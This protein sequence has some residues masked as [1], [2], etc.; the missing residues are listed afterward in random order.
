MDEKSNRCDD[1]IMET[2][3][4]K[5]TIGHI[6][7]FVLNQFSFTLCLFDELVEY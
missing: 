7:I 4:D 1:H 6:D 3:Q 2:L 5:R